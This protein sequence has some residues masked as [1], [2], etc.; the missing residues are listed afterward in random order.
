MMSDEGIKSQ[1]IES[2]IQKWQKEESWSHRK[3]GIM[4]HKFVARRWE[5]RRVPHGGYSAFQNCSHPRQI[6]D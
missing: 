6:L 5:P 3:I 1:E 2:D 4:R